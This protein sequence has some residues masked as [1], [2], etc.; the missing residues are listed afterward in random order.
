LINFHT[1]QRST[2]DQSINQSISI[3]RTRKLIKNHASAR[4]RQDIENKKCTVTNW[5]KNEFSNVHTFDHGPLYYGLNL[6]NLINVHLWS[7]WS[8][9]Q[10]INVH[11]WSKC[12][13]DCGPNLISIWNLWF[14]TSC[15]LDLQST[16]CIEQKC[17]GKIYFKSISIVHLWSNRLQIKYPSMLISL[18][19]Y[20]N[21]KLQNVCVCVI[22]CERAKN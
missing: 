8:T 9:P 6:I 12:T 1:W 20:K 21:F 3:F 4:V 5:W 19:E 15:D 10:L 22:L 11:V 7:S 2:L 16:L 17:I 14:N 18:S 13:L